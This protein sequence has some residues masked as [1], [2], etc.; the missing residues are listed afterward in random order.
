M[1]SKAAS[2]NWSSSL[3]SMESTCFKII[4]SSKKRYRHL[5]SALTDIGVVV[6]GVG[7]ETLLLGL[8]KGSLG[9]HGSHLESRNCWVKHLVEDVIA[10]FNFL[11]LGD[12]WLLKEVRLD[13]TSRE[14]TLNTHVGDRV[15][16]RKIPVC[17]SVFG[18]TCQN[19]MS[20]RSVR[21][22]HCHMTPGLD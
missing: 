6:D 22:W 18:W 11:L 10:A 2:V 4:S 7:K 15:I 16:G 12:P 20:C 17:W 14:F 13:V 21:S 1:I 9:F 8:L 5:C 19:G 3:S